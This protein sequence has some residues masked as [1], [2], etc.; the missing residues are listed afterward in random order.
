MNYYCRIYLRNKRGYHKIAANTLYEMAA[1]VQE[2]CRGRKIV[3]A[4]LIQRV[5]LNGRPTDFVIDFE[6]LWEPW[7]D[8]VLYR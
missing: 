7:N 8:W 4:F 2:Y 1:A 5:D 6:R 3:A